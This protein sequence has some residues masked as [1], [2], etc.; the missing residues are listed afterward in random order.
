MKHYFNNG[1][2]K[3]DLTKS[4][5][6]R[7]PSWKSSW[8]TSFETEKFKLDENRFRRYFSRHNRK[9]IFVLFEIKVGTGRN[10]TGKLLDQLPI[11][12]S[13]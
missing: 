9:C 1:T 12:G 6:G 10:Q 4:E 5:I 3:R 11:L 7:E 8:K 13:M 2:K